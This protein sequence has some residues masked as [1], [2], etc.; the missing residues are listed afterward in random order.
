[1][2]YFIQLECR[3]ADDEGKIVYFIKLCQTLQIQSS[4]YK[5]TFYLL[6]KNINF[7]LKEI[8]YILTKIKFII[9]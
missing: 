1:M 9:N 6:N 4:T 3:R 5:K 7:I 8:N 2:W